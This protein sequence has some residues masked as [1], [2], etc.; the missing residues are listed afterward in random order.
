MG[1]LRSRKSSLSIELTP[2]VDVIF[3]LLVFFMLASTFAN[4]AIKMVLP[5]AT[6]EDKVSKKAVIVSLDA[7][8]QLFVNDQ[9]TSLEMYPALLKDAVQRSNVSSIHIKG[10]QSTP[11]SLFMNVIDLTK[12]AGIDQ[13]NL[14]HEKL[15][16]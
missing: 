6:T 4:P 9:M 11:Y 16:K 5:K 2:L 7:N 12:Q 1:I 13:I 15:D 3:L 10:D 8:G 14:I